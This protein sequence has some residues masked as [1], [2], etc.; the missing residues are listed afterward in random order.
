M[1]PRLKPINDKR[2]AYTNVAA[3]MIGPFVMGGLTNMSDVI[4]ADPAE[5]GR[6]VVSTSSAADDDDDDEA[7][8]QQE[9]LHL[10]AVGQNRNFTLVSF[11]L[12]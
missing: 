11:N 3:I 1:E 5:V 10:V 8:V 4:V 12:A 6:W 9:E 7:T 2:P